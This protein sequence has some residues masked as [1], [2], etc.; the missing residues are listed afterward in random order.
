MP[1]GHAIWKISSP[2][3]R[4]APSS[5]SNEQLLET[6]IVAEPRI[7]SDEWML[8]GRQESTGLGGR[9]DL[10]AI[11]PDG[12]LILIELKRER[13]PR[14]VVAQALDYAT[15]VQKLQPQDIADIYRRF[16]PTRNFIDD[17][18]SRFGQ[19]LEDGDLNQNHQIIIVAS[20]LDDSTERI[21]D[22]LSKRSIPINVL[23]FE[24]FAHGAEQLISRAWLIDPARTQVNVQILPDTPKEP[25]NKEFY[26][27]FGHGSARSWEEA[28]KY[29]FICAGGGAWYS[30]TLKLLKPDDRVWVKAPGFGFVGVG[31]V[32]GPSEPASSF[33]VNTPTGEMPVLETL[34]EGTYH[35]EFADDPDRC[36]YFVPM[37]WLQTVPIERAINEPGLFGNQNTVCKPVT[38]KWPST[39][40]RLQ[41]H[42]PKF[43]DE[44]TNQ[45]LGA[46]ALAPMVA[47]VA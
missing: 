4:L 12:S 13:T 28:V 27:C 45:H 38:P 40:A 34:K 22:Y 21:V 18:R 24:V 6:M 32:T 1:I 7:L 8:I 46:S 42:F 9:I 20:S 16:A 43:A 23:F 41:E 44:P 35:R 33:R 2:P 29:R 37:R 15:W 19:P 3:E 26:A 14:E 10:L 17:F 36:E 30:N 25:W 11:A 5:L 31:R 39:V 47:S